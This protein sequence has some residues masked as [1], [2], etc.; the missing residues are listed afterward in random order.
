MSQDKPLSKPLVI[1]VG[2]RK[3]FKSGNSYVVVLG[4]DYSYLRGRKVY[5]TIEVVG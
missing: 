1:H 4:R 3:V 2:L 5:V